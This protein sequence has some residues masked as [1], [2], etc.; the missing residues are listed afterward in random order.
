MVF[1]FWDPVMNSHVYSK[2]DPTQAV[3]SPLSWLSGTPFSLAS[4]KDAIL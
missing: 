4:K 2:R 1:H 3:A